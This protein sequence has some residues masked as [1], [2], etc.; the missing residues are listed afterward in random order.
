MGFAYLAF[1][2]KMNGLMNVNIGSG[3]WIGGIGGID[4]FL[5]AILNAIYLNAVSA[6]LQTLCLHC[7]YRCIGANDKIFDHFIFL[8]SL[9]TTPFISI[10]FI[11]LVSAPV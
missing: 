1:S 7:S 5:N 10:S 9:P 3:K 4:S 6:M 11:A 2:Q 8:S